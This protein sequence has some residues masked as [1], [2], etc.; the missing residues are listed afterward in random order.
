LRLCRRGLDRSPPTA[1]PEAHHAP[2]GEGT[3]DAGGFSDGPLYLTKRVAS[4]IAKTRLVTPVF[5]CLMNQEKISD[6]TY[7]LQKKV[8]EKI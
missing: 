4:V 1:A 3:P 7:R 8:S 2:K 5:Y 6:I